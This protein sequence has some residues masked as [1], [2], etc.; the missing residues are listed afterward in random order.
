MIRKIALAAVLCGH[1]FSANAQDDVAL[2]GSSY[3]LPRTALRFTLR[4]EKT[5]YKPRELS[6]YAERYFKK[7]A[8]ETEQTT[9]RI[10][11][12]KMAPKGVPDATK[13]FTAKIDDKHGISSLYKND[14]GILLA[15]NTKPEQE[16]NEPPFKP[17]PKPR[18]LNPYNYITQEMA[19][20]ENKAKMASIVA[21][22]I[23]DI[24]NNR[25]RLIKGQEGTNPISENQFDIMMQELNTQEE[26]LMQLF[27]GVSNIDTIETN[28]DYIPDHEVKHEV[29]FRFSKYYGLVR[30]NDLSG[31]PYYI[32]IKDDHTIPAGSS[33][34]PLTEKNKNDAG[35]WVNLP[36]KITAQLYR[37]NELLDTYEVYA[38][39]FG[40]TEPMIGDLFVRKM[41]TKVVL[42][43]TTGATRSINVEL[44]K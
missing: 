24:R 23:F 8:S 22:E 31:T 43:P 37:E 1:I 29:V 20:A 4:I 25:N 30:K 3:F 21:D 11:N 18:K 16:E 34:V 35:I 19:G 12:I 5:R 41:A 7:A 6:R 40:R 39:Q 9:Y 32:C 15:I 42:D 13:A 36:G 33:T 17:A 44:R 27:Y 38:G 10:L 26:A 2:N 28:I 14:E